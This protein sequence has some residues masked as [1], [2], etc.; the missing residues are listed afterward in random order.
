M[1]SPTP[2]PQDTGIARTQ[3]TDQ[4]YTRDQVAKDCVRI[5]IESNTLPHHA[6][7]IEPAAGTGAFL[8]ALQHH[9]PQ[10]TALAF[11]THPKHPAV[12]KLDFLTWEPIPHK[13]IVV[14]GN[15]PFGR[16][17]AH[18]NAFIRNA[19][20]FAQ[21]IAFILPRSFTKPSTHNAFPPHFHLRSSTPLPANSFI[22]NDQPHDVKCVFQIWTREPTPRPPTIRSTPHHFEY[23]R[24]PH[25]DPGAHY[26]LAL[27]RVGGTAGIAHLPGLAFHNPSTH[28]FIR[29]RLPSAKPAAPT[30]TPHNTPATT[31]H[32]ARL[33]HT[34]LNSPAVQQ[35]LKKNNTTG[36]R[37]IGQSE[38]TSI[39]NPF[40][41]AALK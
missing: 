11:D 16:K 40:I 37:S 17:L 10:R 15:P 1:A 8:R 33:L 6:T 35:Q 14:F 2:Q 26:D 24:N 34:H 13:N 36:P 23:T 22:V 27:R 21:V 29:L 31:T 30:T 3:L 12:R 9:L 28:Y 19:A 39:I 38:F 41:D 20:Q 5:L 7:W 32:I 25:R 18:A 4:F